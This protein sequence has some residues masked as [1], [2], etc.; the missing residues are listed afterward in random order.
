MGDSLWNG[1]KFRILNIIDDF[2][3]EVLSVEADTSLPA[4]RVIRVLDQSKQTSGLPQMIRVVI[5]SELL[6]F[7]LDHYCR[8]NHITLVFI[9]PGKP[10]QNAFTERCNGSIRKELLSAYVFQSLSDVREKF[11]E[12]VKDYN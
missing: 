9:Q 7:K 6:S 11:Q 3:R 1:R 8:Q 2:N 5:G 12:W 4:L 10:M